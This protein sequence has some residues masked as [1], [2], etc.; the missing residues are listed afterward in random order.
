MECKGN[1]AYNTCDTDICSAART[2]AYTDLPEDANLVTTKKDTLDEYGKYIK[3]TTNGVVVSADLTD[4][5]YTQV[6]VTFVAIDDFSDLKLIDWKDAMVACRES[7][8]VDPLKEL[9]QQ[10]NIDWQK[11]LTDTCESEIFGAPAKEYK[12]CYEGC[13]TKAYAELAGVDDA[14]TATNVAAYKKLIE[15]YVIADSSE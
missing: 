15:D 1:T 6:C 10:I 12:E 8:I 9:E 7:C 13:D 11:C 4:A 3:C 5:V 2:K 14:E